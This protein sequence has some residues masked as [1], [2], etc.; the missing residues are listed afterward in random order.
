MDKRQDFKS[1]VM[2]VRLLVKGCELE[3][4]FILLSK[5]WLWCLR[6]LVKEQLKS[7]FKT[8][9]KFNP[10]RNGKAFQLK[11]NK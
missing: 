1:E 7:R 4:S 8:T 2:F 11:H 10:N 6:N 3:A 5:L 9:N